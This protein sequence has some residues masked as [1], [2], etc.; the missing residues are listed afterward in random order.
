MQSSMFAIIDQPPPCT[1]IT[2]IDSGCPM[3]LHGL[4]LTTWSD[5]VSLRTSPNGQESTLA[6]TVGC[7]RESFLSFVYNSF[8]EQS[9]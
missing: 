6:S 3:A 8:P 4:S 5:K 7:I 9:F 2:I 1:S